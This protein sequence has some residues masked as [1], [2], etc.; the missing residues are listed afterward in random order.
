[1][2]FTLTNFHWMT[3]ERSH[4]GRFQV[5][6]AKTCRTIELK[7]SCIFKAGYKGRHKQ[8]DKCPEMGYL[9]LPLDPE[10]QPAI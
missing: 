1:M 3:Y 5:P 7:S 4:K 10:P 9:K 6:D 2:G 8:L